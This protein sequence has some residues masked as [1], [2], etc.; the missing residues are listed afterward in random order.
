LQTKDGGLIILNTLMK[1]AVIC[2]PAAEVCHRSQ[3]FCLAALSR[4][5]SSEGSITIR[6]EREGMK[7]HG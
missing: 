7:V 2:Q 5:G 4:V 1:H 6:L 3:S